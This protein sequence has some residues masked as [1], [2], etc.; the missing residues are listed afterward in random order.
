MAA[1]RR[2][3]RLPPPP[4]PASPDELHPSP[5][6]WGQAAVMELQASKESGADLVRKEAAQAAVELHTQLQR[7]QARVKRRRGGGFVLGCLALGLCWSSPYA[8]RSS[9]CA[10]THHIRSACRCVHMPPHRRCRLPCPAVQAQQSKQEA[11]LRAQ[12]A[13]LQAAAREKAGALSRLG[14]SQSA[15][16]DVTAQVEVLQAQCHD[17]KVRKMVGGRGLPH[18]PPAAEE[19]QQA[20][21]ATTP[22]PQVQCHGLKPSGLRL[23]GYKPWNAAPATTPQQ[24]PQPHP[25]PAVLCRC[26]WRRPHNRRWRRCWR[27]PAPAARPRPGMQAQRAAG[28]PAP[29]PPT[30][31]RRGRRWGWRCGGWAGAAA[32]AAAVLRRRRPPRRRRIGRRWRSSCRGGSATWNGCCPWLTG[33]H[34]ALH[35]AWPGVPCA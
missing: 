10:A 28:Q 13:A 7:L 3:P 16:D 23:R 27:Q 35:A 12:Q 8:A 17:L 26:A 33:G 14:D 11:E 2:I 9:L 21:T 20:T 5:P 15:L 31:R 6:P 29:G 22:L 24:H 19:L 30:R 32:A 34:R 25:Q 1:G 4:S 18:P